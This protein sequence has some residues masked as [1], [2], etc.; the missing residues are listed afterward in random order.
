MQAPID[1][2]QH[3][4]PRWYQKQFEDAMFTGKKRALLVWHRRAGKDIAALNFMVNEMLKKVG[5]YY[6]FFPTF[7]QARGVIWDGIDKSGKRIIDAF[8][9][10]VIEKKNES[11]MKIKLINGSLFQMV[12]TDNFD[13]IAGTNPIGCVFSEFS[14]QNPQAW[15]LI[16]SPILNQNN[17]WAVFVG[18]PR[19]KNH[20]YELDE[21]A[22][23]N[24]QTWFYSK[25][26]IDDTKLLT[27]EDVDRI[28]N[29]EG[30]S[31]ETAYQEYWCSYERGQDGTYYG[32]LVNKAKDEGRIGNVAYDQSSTVCTAWDIGFGDSTS[33][34]FYQV[35]GTEVRV[36]DFYENH[37]ESIAHYVKVVRDK[38]YI[39]SAHYLPHDAGSSSIQTGMTLQK[40]L[41]E[42]GL[43]TIILPRDDIAVGIEAV[44]VIL[45]Q[46]FIDEKK[47]RHLI[48]CLEN[49]H[50]KFNDK[51]NCYSETPVHDFTS[52]ACDAFR[53]MAMARQQFGKGQ[54]SLTPSAIKDMRQRNIGY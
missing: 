46:C 9:K 3:Y 51:M 45:S 4:Q 17:G 40:K 27:K 48:K 26:T 30:I 22:R 6:Y 25:L 43:Q 19:G 7:K 53:Y 32:K 10:E 2:T 50:K 31:E 1:L 20:Q 37:G 15:R 28:M 52:H 33:I 11:E 49:Y 54:G 42:L 39:Y 41:I 21:T 24:P 16:V 29:E 35:I 23:A 13:S 38:P 5:V 18:T 47:C 36:I 14:L 34:V 8:P 44:R 12:G